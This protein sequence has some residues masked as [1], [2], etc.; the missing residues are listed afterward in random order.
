MTSSRIL[1]IMKHES[2]RVNLN[3][4]I[5]CPQPP[6]MNHFFSSRPRTNREAG[7]G[8]EKSENIQRP[9]RPKGR[10]GI[11][12]ALSLPLSSAHV[13][14]TRFL[15]DTSTCL[16]FRP[17]Q[18]FTQRS[19]HLTPFPSCQRMGEQRKRDTNTSLFITKHTWWNG[20]R[21]ACYFAP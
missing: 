20:G 18:T 15:T 3:Q 14:C 8:G 10:T 5:W 7:G 17:S 19:S 6:L 13:Q 9:S 2:H 12:K 11:S 4:S 16:R 1:G 21:V